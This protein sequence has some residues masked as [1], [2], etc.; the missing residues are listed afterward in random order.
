[1]ATTTRVEGLRELEKALGNL[2]KAVGKRFLRNALKEMAKPIADDY[3]SQAPRDEGSL[4]DSIGVGTKLTRRQ[5]SLHRRMFRDDRA[6]AEVFAGAGGLP[7]AHLKE[8]GTF[9]E[10][11]QPAL[12]PAWDSNKGNLIPAFSKKAWD[13]IDKRAKREARKAARL[14]KKMGG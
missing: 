1:M 6:S 11:A 8:F 13:Q 4:R 12:R 10:P 2:P 9:K 5:R 3:R 7:Q 14:A